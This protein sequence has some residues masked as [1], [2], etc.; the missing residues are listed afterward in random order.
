MNKIKF[1]HIIVGITFMANISVFQLG[2]GNVY[3]GILFTVLI[4][5]LITSKRPNLN[6]LMLLFLGVALLSIIMNDIPYFFRPYERFI[7]FVLI[8]SLIGPF[9]KTKRLDLFKLQLFKTL[10]IIIVFFVVLSFIGLLIKAPF[11][12]GRGGFTGFFNHTM[13]LGPMAAISM[14]SCLNWGRNTSKKKKRIIYYALVFI[15]FVVCLAAGSRAALIAGALGSLF[16][17]YKSNKQN[18]SKFSK[19]VFISVSLGVL[20]FP[21]WEQYTERVIGKIIFSE[22]QGDLAVTRSY[23]WERRLEEFNSSPII[24]IGFSNDSSQSVNDLFIGEGQIEPGSSWLVILSMIGL[25][26]FIPLI[27]LL[28]LAFYFI[29]KNKGRIGILPHLGALLVFFMVH[30]FAEGYVLSAGSGLFFYFWLLMGVISIH[31]NKKEIKL[32]VR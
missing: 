30:M 10:N 2:L 17:F 20:T 18:L 11:L 16:F 13:M 12:Y 27:I 7:I 9:L 32:R 24:G 25:L 6:Y 23:L 3:Y 22:E 1:V 31:Q 21:L 19:I 28:I 15:G 5:L 26:G 29:Y 8:V 4:I 14:L